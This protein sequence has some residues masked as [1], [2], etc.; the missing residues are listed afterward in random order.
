MSASPYP[1]GAAPLLQKNHRSPGVP[2]Q[3][4][5]VRRLD[6]SRH[7]YFHV[8][9]CETRSRNIRAGSRKPRQRSHPDAP[10]ARRPAPLPEPLLRHSP[11]SWQTPSLPQSPIAI[12]CF[13]R[14][15][16]TSGFAG[17]SFQTVSPRLKAVHP[18]TRRLICSKNRSKSSPPH[19]Q[20]QYITIC[21]IH[22]PMHP[23]FSS[24][25]LL[26]CAKMRA[27]FSILFLSRAN[28]DADP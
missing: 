19:P 18:F 28:W 8:E 12:R 15:I 11:N 21:G 17:R 4:A 3:A 1:I 22:Q 25:S 10:Q 27:V 6:R 24:F 5:R 14:D 2:P 26:D 23:A 7:R 20:P 13:R 9:P 16:M